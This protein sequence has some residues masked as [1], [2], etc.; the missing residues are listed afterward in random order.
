MVRYEGGLSPPPKP[1][2]FPLASR[3]PRLGWLRLPG[4]RRCVLG[5]VRSGAAVGVG[6]SGGARRCGAGLRSGL[7]ARTA[8][9]PPTDRT[10]RARRP[11]GRVPHR[12]TPDGRR[13]PPE[14]RSAGRKGEGGACGR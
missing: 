2:P 9:Q 6:R 13:T 7:R 14:K 12:R 5:P 8:A 1:L 11:G 3:A 10:R 4:R